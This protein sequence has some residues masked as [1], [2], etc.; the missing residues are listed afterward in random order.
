MKC[1]DSGARFLGFDT[2][3]RRSVSLSKDTFSPPKS[4]GNTQEAVAP[5]PKN[6][7][8][9]LA[10]TKPKPS[11]NFF[12]SFDKSCFSLFH[13]E[14]PFCLYNAFVTLVAFFSPELFSIIRKILLRFN[15]FTLKYHFAYIIHLLHLLPFF[16][17][18]PDF[19]YHCCLFNIETPFCLY[20]VTLVALFSVFPENISG[21]KFHNEPPYSL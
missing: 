9:R 5:S 4:T 14:I 11:Q 16:S 3:H 10:L 6:L 21:S 7:P 15:C 20:N 2:Y 8:G 17:A 1:M 12:L 13:I 19:Y 18:F